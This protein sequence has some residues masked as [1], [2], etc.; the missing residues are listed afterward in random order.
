MNG[1]EVAESAGDSSKFCGGGAK[2]PGGG[3]VE[4][5]SK[6]RGAIKGES[7]GGGGI[8]GGANIFKG[9]GVLGGGMGAGASLLGGGVSKAAER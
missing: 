3:G 1:D 6:C 9:G 7:K 8:D 4:G 2:G 5:G